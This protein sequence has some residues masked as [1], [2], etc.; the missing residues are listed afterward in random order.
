MLQPSSLNNVVF[1]QNFLKNWA[2]G[3]WASH[4]TSYMCPESRFFKY[5]WNTKEMCSQS[6]HLEIGL[7]FSCSGSW[8][9]YFPEY[10]TLGSIQEVVEFSGHFIAWTGRLSRPLSS[11]LES[12]GQ[13]NFIPKN[14]S[15]RPKQVSAHKSNINNASKKEREVAQSCLI[16]CYPV[17]YTVN[18]ILQARILEWVAFPFSRGSSQTR[19]QTQVSCIAGRF[20]T[21]WATRKARNNDSFLAITLASSSRSFII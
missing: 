2:T 4:C 13:G 14:T 9:G 7:L 8:C 1:N 5:L 15:G 19:D 11:L 6:V 12:M 17:D 16:L 21:T 10:K 18:G 3:K 20:F